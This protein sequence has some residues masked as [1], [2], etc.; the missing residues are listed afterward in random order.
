MRYGFCRNSDGILVQKCYRKKLLFLYRYWSCCYTNNTKLALEN[1]FQLNN[2][3][4]L[5]L[6]ESEVEIATKSAEKAY[7]AWMNFNNGININNNDT[8]NKRSFNGYNYSNK[9][10]IDMFNITEEEIENLSTIITI[11]EKRRRDK[12]RK[13]LKRK[14]SNGLTAK[15]RELKKLREKIMI[16]RQ[17][18]YSIRK[19]GK[20]LGVS[21][22][23]IQRNITT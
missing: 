11:D 9:K 16:L 20:K 18:G 23:K 12:L 17:E 13:Q 7:I 15:Q 4:N 8:D 19:I 10:L 6:S 21:P 2:K 22:S 5:P 1:T 3:F 14:D